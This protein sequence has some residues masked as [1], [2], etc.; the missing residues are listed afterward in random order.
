MTLPL[1]L[2]ALIWKKHDS[3]WE[4]VWNATFFTSVSTTREPRDA[5]MLLITRPWALR[6][7]VQNYPLNH[8]VS[9]PP[10]HHHGCGSLHMPSNIQAN[11]QK[12]N[13][14]TCP[15]FTILS[16]PTLHFSLF[17]HEIRCSS[18]RDICAFFHIVMDLPWTRHSLLGYIPLHSFLALWSQRIQSFSA[19]TL[20][21][22]SRKRE[23]NSFCSIF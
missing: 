8:P 9:A 12:N 18:P 5:K 1:P 10:A 20:K 13:Y 2:E 19:I 21:Q 15:P 3:L 22:W 6:L 16:L 11:S 14:E 17:P 23:I 7:T 4:G